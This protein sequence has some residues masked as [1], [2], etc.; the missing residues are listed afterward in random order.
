MQRLEAFP[1]QRMVL[2]ENNE[3]QDE[4]TEVI[5]IDSNGQERKIYYI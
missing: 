2:M 3:I 4:I 5:L 1:K